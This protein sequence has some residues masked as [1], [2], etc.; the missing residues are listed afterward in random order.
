MKARDP[1]LAAWQSTVSRRG[2]DAAVFDST[3]K[4]AR[5]FRDVEKGARAFYTKIDA[6]PAGTVVAVQIGNHKDWP[7]VFIACV[8]KQLVFFRLT[9]PSASDSAMRL[10][11]F[12]TQTLSYPPQ[13]WRERT[14]PANLTCR[15]F[16][17]LPVLQ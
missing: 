16:R 15:S 3:G 17:W 12:A 13:R 4:V 7:S 8:R 2:G 6:F 1:L 11:K 10:W 14:S 9:N 5:S